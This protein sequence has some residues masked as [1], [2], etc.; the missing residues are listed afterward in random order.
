[1]DGTLNVSAVAVRYG[2][3]I[4]GCGDCSLGPNWSCTFLPQPE[5]PPFRPSGY[6]TFDRA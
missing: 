6:S 1:M 2:P 3:W 4:Q 5:R